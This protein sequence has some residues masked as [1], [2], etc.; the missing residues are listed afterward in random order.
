MRQRFHSIY[1]AL[2]AAVLF[3]P[4]TASS[5]G[6]DYHRETI[7]GGGVLL[8]KESR[9]LPMVTIRVSI[10]AGT[11]A[12]PP[13]KQGL[14]NITAALLAR[15]TRRRSS[16]DI[17]RLNDLLGGGIGMEAGRDFATAT[18]RVLT[19][20]IERG[21]DLLADALRR[22]S[23]PKKEVEK[24]RRQI[25]GQFR[26]RK[27]RPSHLADV[28]LRKRI[29]GVHPYG[30]MVS[31]TPESVQ[32]IKRADIRT[33]YR[34]WYGMKGAIFVFVGDISTARAREIVLANFKGWRA[35]KAKLPDISLESPPNRFIVEKIDRTLTQT[36]VL[37]GNRSLKRKHPDFYAARVMNY[38]LAGGGF[39]SRI[40]NNIR[41]EKGLVYAAY[42]YFAAGMDTGHW[43]LV[44]QTKNESANEAIAE[45]L[46]EIRRMQEK[47]VT[48][49][50]L[51][52]AKA[53]IT[54]NFA[55]RFLSSG[56]IAGYM[57]AIE[58]L[59]FPSD[60]AFRYLERIRAVTKEQVQEA[61]KKYIHPDAAILAVVG[62]LSEAKLKY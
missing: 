12:E 21:M 47:G 32:K 1:L 16:A 9:E 48:E 15:G 55:T 30:R 27:D 13:E 45:S 20:D 14:A 46:A 44:L 8:V 23:F 52:D 34:N 17:E 29:F 2:F 7:P 11:R 38:I 19:K 36:T 41:E 4:L 57:L 24:T 5:A 3:S 37:I 40:L 50:E 42:S 18:L 10:S 31:G 59:G 33:F 35:G 53:F 26:R 58:R 49:K 28:A 61:A 56:R 39:E 60:Y 54:G 51:A 62:N 25:I 43:R 22:P 6:F